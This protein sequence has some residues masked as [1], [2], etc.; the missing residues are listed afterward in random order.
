V[1]AG[2]FLTKKKTR[3]GKLWVKNIELGE[4]AENFFK[5]DS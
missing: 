3:P 2:P 1:G 4:A 5:A